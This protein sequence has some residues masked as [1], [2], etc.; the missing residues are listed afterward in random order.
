[1][2]ANYDLKYLIPLTTLKDNG[3]G[4]VIMALARSLVAQGADVTM[5]VS[6]YHGTQ[7]QF[8]EENKG[9]QFVI[10]PAVYSSKLLS[11]LLLW[12]WGAVYSFWRRP[13]L[14][15]THIITGLIPNFS[16]F[17]PFWLAQDLEYRFFTGKKRWLMKKVLFSIAHKT[18]LVV[19]SNWLALFFKR[20]HCHLVFSAD[21]GISR[22][23]SAPN[24]LGES[25]RSIDFLLIAKKGTHKRLTETRAVA[26]KLAEQG[27][28]VTLI[29][30]DQSS[31][32]VNLPPLLSIYDAVTPSRMRTFFEDTSVFISLSRAEGYGLTPLEALSMGCEVVTTKTPSTSGLCHN[33]LYVLIGS[34]S[35]IE[36]ATSAATL[37]LVKTNGRCNESHPIVYAGPFMD[38]WAYSAA[39][40][41]LGSQHA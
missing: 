4:A 25:S 24:K 34:D 40:M 10:V 22:N 8:R 36:R 30:Q 27:F 9:I 38:A 20:I 41:I 26:I 31:L 15:Y 14:I 21:V 17:Q 23:F 37:A 39:K 7:P 29:D 13:C 6:N 33:S 19:T 12:M 1:M 3:G 11:M 32:E 18:S 2:M 35:L 5:L 28:R 16:K